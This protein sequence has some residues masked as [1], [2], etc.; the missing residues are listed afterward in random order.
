[1]IIPIISYLREIAPEIRKIDNK[2]CAATVTGCKPVNTVIPPKIP[3]PKIPSICR[4]ASTLTRFFVMAFL[5][6][7]KAI[8][9]TASAVKRRTKV[10]SRLPNSIQACSCP[11]A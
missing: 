2:K 11:S 8:I 4:P 1:M 3:C 6:L 9:T 5:E 10:S 7:L